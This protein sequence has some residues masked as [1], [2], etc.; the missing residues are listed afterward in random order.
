MT[1]NHHTKQKEMK[2]TQNANLEIHRSF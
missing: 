1:F 2:K